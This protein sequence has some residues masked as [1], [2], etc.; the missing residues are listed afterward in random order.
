MHSPVIQKIES[1]LKK[2]VKKDIFLY[3]I[4]KHCKNLIYKCLPKKI[5]FYIQRYIFNNS[6]FLFEEQLEMALLFSKEILD[7]TLELFNPKSV[8]DLGCGAGK[9]LDYFLSKGIFAVGVDGSKMAIRKS[10]HPESIIRHNLERELNLN[11]KFD[12]VWSFEFV[13]H[14]H[15]RFINNLL[16][17]FSN[18]SDRVVMSAARPEQKGF[19]HFNEQPA[20][21]WIKQF[22]K[23]GYRFNKD[24]TEEFRKINEPLVQNMLVFER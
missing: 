23:Y 20:A 11:K 1:R 15:P 12:L 19:W 8:L 2:K 21:Y 4:L 16:R 22:E 10:N 7:K 3:A 17:T 6:I 24:K 18:H 9:S 5:I 14:I 13:E